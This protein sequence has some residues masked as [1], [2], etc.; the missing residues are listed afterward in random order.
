MKLQINYV[1]KSGDHFISSVSEYEDVKLLHA[2]SDKDDGRLYAWYYEKATLGKKPEFVKKP[3][4]DFS[5]P[6]FPQFLITRGVPDEL[7]AAYEFYIVVRRTIDDFL[8]SAKGFSGLI[9]DIET[10]L[11]QSLS[12]DVESY[13]L[14]IKLLI[15]EGAVYAYK[16][17]KSGEYLS[18]TEMKAN[19]EK[20][21][22]YYGS[23]AN[24]L[25]LKSDKINLLVS[26]DQ[27]VGN[28]R[29]YLLREF[30]KKHIPSK[31]S[32]ATG[33]IEGYSRQVDIIIYDSQNFSPSFSEGD[34]VVVAQEAVR[35]VIEVKTNLITAKLK[36]ALEFFHHISLPG[37]RT[38]RLPM[39]KGVFAFDTEY[40]T[41]QSIAEYIKSFYND[42]YFEEDLQEKI[43]RD[44]MY[45][46]HEVTCVAVI[47]KQ[48][49]FSQYN[50]ANGND[51]DHV[52][53][54]LYSV[55]DKKG[56]DVQTA[57]FIS[58]LFNYLDTDYYSKTSSIWDYGKFRDSTTEGKKECNLTAD[59]W[60][61]RTHRKDEHGHD[62]ESVRNRVKKIKEWFS[63]AIST[64]EL[65]STPNVTSDVS[66]STE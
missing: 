59:D 37:F 18:F 20:R 53:P 66:D 22:Q 17:L 15:A 24:E 21:K 7:K 31:F 29:E 54:I 65:L 3:I 9:S 40:T 50:S 60:L 19:H 14:I 48:C 5:E 32:V 4:E 13:Q 64:T 2:Y 52:I 63:G 8:L 26:H 44:V 38:S 57:M 23:L 62:K 25:K 1:P 46:Y 36:E 43:I 51:S 55:S 6:F 35:A 33:F 49:V 42:P 34:L 28:Y 39:F 41:S 12:A 27:T 10:H 16:K 61:P 56:R 47:G 58:I 11:I 30:L 45:L